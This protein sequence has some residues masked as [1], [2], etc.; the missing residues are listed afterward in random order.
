V[1]LSVNG[2]ITHSSATY[3]EFLAFLSGGTG[4][5]TLQQ[6]GSGA[7]LALTD[8]R[9]GANSRIGVSGSFITA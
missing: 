6:I 3:T 5:I 8:A 1:S 9:F 4:T 2:D 7:V